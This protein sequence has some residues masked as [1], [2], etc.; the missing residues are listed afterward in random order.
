MSTSKPCPNAPARVGDARKSTGAS[1]AVTRPTGVTRRNPF[2][3][4][5]EL[6]DSEEEKPVSV[7]TRPTAVTTSAVAAPCVTAAAT[8]QAMLDADPL[9]QAMARGDVLWGDLMLA[10]EEAEDR[11]LG[12]VRPVYDFAAARAARAEYEAAEAE[13]EQARQDAAEGALWAQPFG[14]NLEMYWTDVYDTRALTDAEYEAC[15]TWLYDQGWELQGEQRDGF[16]G[17]PADLPPRVWVSTL[18][19]RFAALH[20]APETHVHTSA[21]NHAPA[22]AGGRPPRAP[23]ARVTVPRFCRAVPCTDEACRY[24]HEDTMPRLDKPCGFGAACGGTDPAKRAQCLY[25]H[26]GETWTP[27]LVVTRPSAPVTDGAA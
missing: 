26:P 13:A 3:Q 17:W 10:E 21:C 5:A 12:R 25:M 22:P 14:R 15:M 20:A 1:S 19:N 23:R 4:L 24:V 6:S 11:R 18:P 16:K 2:S 9:I 8:L 7:V 27:E